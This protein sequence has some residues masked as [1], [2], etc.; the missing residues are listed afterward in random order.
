[1]NAT[2]NTNVAGRYLTINGEKFYLI[3]NYNQMQPFF[4]S[5]ASDTDLWMY[6]SSTGGLTCGRRNPEQVLFPYYTDDKVTEN[7]EH[8]GAKTLIRILSTSNSPL[9]ST[10]NS[11]LSTIVWEPFSDRY[12]GVYNIQ[13]SIAK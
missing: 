3:E 5:L 11:Q 13:R 12:M 6:I 9:L 8:T 2:E 4:I 10:P 1:M 7:Y